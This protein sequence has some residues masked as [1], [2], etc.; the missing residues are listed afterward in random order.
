[1]DLM[2]LGGMYKVSDIFY[3]ST[4]ICTCPQLCSWPVWRAPWSSWC[5]LLGGTAC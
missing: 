3:N 5:R 1:M 2:L 4:L